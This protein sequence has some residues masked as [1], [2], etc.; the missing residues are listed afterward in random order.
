[1]SFFT[2]FR[3]SSVA[4]IHASCSAFAAAALQEHSHDNFASAPIKTACI[5]PSLFILFHPE[6]C[7]M[8]DCMWSFGWGEF[9]RLGCGDACSQ[10]APKPVAFFRRS[11]ARFIC[12]SCGAHHRYPPNLE[13]LFLS[14]F[15]VLVS[16]RMEM[17]FV[18][19]GIHMGNWVSF[20]LGLRMRSSCSHA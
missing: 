18:G 4:L 19:V 9:G 12:V 17:C 1:V 20:G 6:F 13:I 2:F 8:T 16:L 11:D 7:S 14:Y 15:A 5:L 10:L 3:G